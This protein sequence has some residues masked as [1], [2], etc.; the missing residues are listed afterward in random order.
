MCKEIEILITFDKID[1]VVTEWKSK[2]I[3]FF[4]NCK[5]ITTGES[6][7]ELK[8][9]GSI[10]LLQVLKIGQQYTITC[11]RPINKKYVEYPY[12]IYCK[13]SKETL[14]YNLKTKKFDKI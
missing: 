3:L 10:N 6:Y 13:K 12:K 2:T 1:N 9:K 14:I 11:K 7:K 8:Y 5:N 4:S